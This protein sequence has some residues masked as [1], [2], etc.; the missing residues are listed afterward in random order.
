MTILI[1]IL[2]GIGIYSIIIWIWHWLVTCECDPVMPAVR[3]ETCYRISEQEQELN[4]WM[5]ERN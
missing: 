1:D 5:A 4:R 2:A 3:D